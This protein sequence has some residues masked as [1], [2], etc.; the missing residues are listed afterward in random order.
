VFEA[1]LGDLQGQF[2]GVSDLPGDGLV[3]DAEIF[4]A[5]CIIANMGGVHLVLAAVGSD[6]TEDTHLS[7]VEVV[8]S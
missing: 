6:I 4:I 5:L 8:H 7:D 1:A 3:V 2:F